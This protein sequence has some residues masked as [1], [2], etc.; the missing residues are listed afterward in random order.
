MCVCQSGDDGQITDVYS[1][2]L[3]DGGTERLNVTVV[4]E[5]I[6]SSYTILHLRGTLPLGFDFTTDKGKCLTCH[7]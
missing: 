1:V 5:D 6:L 7:L 3:L 2:D 4:E